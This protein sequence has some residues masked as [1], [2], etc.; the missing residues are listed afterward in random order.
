MDMH[1]LLGTPDGIEYFVEPHVLTSFTDDEFRSAFMDA[2]IKAEWDAEGARPRVVDR[3][4]VT[5][6]RP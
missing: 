2:G 6:S 5:L 1:Y 3:A 4:E